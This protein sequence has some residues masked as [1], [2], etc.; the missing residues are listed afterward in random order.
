LPDGSKSLV[1]V[2][3]TSAAAGEAG[4]ALAGAATVG[5]TGDLLAVCA[6]I[7]AFSA[8]NRDDREQAARNPPAR[9]DDRAACP[10]QFAAG[11]GSGA[12]SDP[13]RPAPPD[14]PRH[15]AGAAGRADGPGGGRGDGNGRGGGEW[16]WGRPT[17]PA[18]P[19]PA[20]PRPHS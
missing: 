5:A 18:P 8:R 16:R 3:W 13:D 19:P 4:P 7:A 6:L 10:A 2:A 15:G 17:G 1:P 14:T 9:E 20:P 12:T 11:R